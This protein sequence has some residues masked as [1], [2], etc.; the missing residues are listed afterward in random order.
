MYLLSRLFLIATVALAAYS[1]LIVIVLTWPA[2]G[3]VLGLYAGA[4]GL[5]RQ[6]QRLTTL[7]SARWAEEGELR[8]LGMLG[9][10]CGLI[11]GRL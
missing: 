4:L 3:W 7:G 9:G 6:R 8:H 10:S 11:L 1:G 5:N 2:S